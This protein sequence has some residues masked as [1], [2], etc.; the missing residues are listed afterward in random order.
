MLAIRKLFSS[1]SFLENLIAL[2][3][4]YVTSSFSLRQRFNCHT[5]LD[6]NYDHFKNGNTLLIVDTSTIDILHQATL[7]WKFN[8]R[9]GLRLG[10]PLEGG[11]FT[12]AVL[13]VHPLFHWS[14][15]RKCCIQSPLKYVNKSNLSKTLEVHPGAL[16]SQ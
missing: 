10:T 15:E 5:G 7:V 14:W 12:N 9:Q 3:R 11:M 2:Q 6:W 16:V 8:F 1:A 4:S 13:F